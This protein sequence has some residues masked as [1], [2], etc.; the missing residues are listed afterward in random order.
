ML[1]DHPA[2]VG[3][4]HPHQALIF[5]TDEELRF[6]RAS[7][8][9]PPRPLLM[10][11]RRLAASPHTDDG[12]GLARD[13]GESDIPLGEGS[14]GWE[15]GLRELDPEDVPGRGISHGARVCPS[16]RDR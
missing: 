16:V 9:H 5:E 3:G 14:W 10:E 12:Q 13:L 15:D 2:Q 7:L 4:L 6:G 8:C 11:K 1:G